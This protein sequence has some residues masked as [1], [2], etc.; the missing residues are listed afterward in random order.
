[1]RSWG[2]LTFRITQNSGPPLLPIC[3]FSKKLGARWG[4]GLQDGGND[5][6]QDH[7]CQHLPGKVQSTALLVVTKSTF[8]AQSHLSSWFTSHRQSLAHKNTLHLLH[9]HT[10]LFHSADPSIHSSFSPL[11]LG[12]F[13]NG[14]IWQSCC[15]IA[16]KAGAPAGRHIAFSFKRQLAPDPHG[17]FCISIFS[18]DI[19]DHKTQD[20]QTTIL[21]ISAIFLV[22]KVFSCSLLLFCLL[23]C[24][25]FHWID[26]KMIQ[27]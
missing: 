10:S 21:P 25:T 4:L 22:L 20:T 11:A 26:K 23:L 7:L 6:N 14:A 17:P 9:Y 19:K 1:M 8:K 27:K 3:T 18:K 15:Q 5:G 24:V 13:H 2:S 12:S 16:G